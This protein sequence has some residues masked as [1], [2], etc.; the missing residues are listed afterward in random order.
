ML[1]IVVA[2]GAAVA[3]WAVAGCANDP[4]REALRRQ[5]RAEGVPEYVQAQT[6]QRATDS[7]GERRW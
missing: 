2:L 7:F 3:A 4:Q 1:K 6:R 5:Q